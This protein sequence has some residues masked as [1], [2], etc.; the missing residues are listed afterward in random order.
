MDKKGSNKKK[1]E[2]QKNGALMTHEVLR[3]YF[4]ANSLDPFELTKEQQLCIADIAKYWLIKHGC[5]IA[6][7]S[8]GGDKGYYTIS[9][10]VICILMLLLI[11]KYLPV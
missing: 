8:K 4:N 10:I 9:L 5:P 2:G 3:I 11:L 1:E 6:K 7:L